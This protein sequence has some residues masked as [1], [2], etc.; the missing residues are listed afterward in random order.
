M[1]TLGAPLD[2]RGTH[3]RNRCGIDEE[4]RLNCEP[5]L[6]ACEYQHLIELLCYNLG[7]QSLWKRVS[8]VMMGSRRNIQLPDDI[9]YES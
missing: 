6:V 4:L 9:A 7:W 1:W 8:F 5:E 3:S 2:K